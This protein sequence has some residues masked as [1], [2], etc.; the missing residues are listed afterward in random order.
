MW[1]IFHYKHLF[2]SKNFCDLQFSYAIRIM[3]LFVLLAQFTYCIATGL[4]VLRDS[5][6]VLATLYFFVHR[7]IFLSYV[8]RLYLI[9]NYI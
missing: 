3:L 1:I 9:I 2:V 8:T 6:L 7:Y 5:V 4:F